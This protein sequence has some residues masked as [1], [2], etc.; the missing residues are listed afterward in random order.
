MS[1]LMPTIGVKYV[2][3]LWTTESDGP[4]T[5][6]HVRQPNPMFEREISINQFQLEYFDKVIPDIAESSMFS[7]A[8]GHGHTPV[9]ILGHLAI[10]SELGQKLLGGSIS[11]PDWIERFGPRSVDDIA[12]DDSLTLPLVTNALR[13]GYRELC[14]LAASTTDQ[15]ALDR[16]H[17][18]PSLTGT[19]IVTVA[20]TIALLLTNHFAFHLS[21][22]S[23]CRRSA[24][25]PPLF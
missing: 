8:P 13:D 9:W 15:A 22:L 7:P 5:A 17:G 24:G 1:K 20:D 18:M 3:G 6:T 12:P 4:T 10:C 2:D 21:Q 14:N 11:H 16:P 25:M 19:P 23:S